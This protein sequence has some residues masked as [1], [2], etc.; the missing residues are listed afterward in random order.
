MTIV[1]DYYNCNENVFF[2]GI[3]NN[4][5]TSGTEILIVVRRLFNANCI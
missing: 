2:G 4:I 5:V 3:I 1:C